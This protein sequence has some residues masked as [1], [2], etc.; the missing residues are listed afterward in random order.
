MTSHFC[1]TFLSYLPRQITYLHVFEPQIHFEGPDSTVH[2]A[3]DVIHN[4]AIGPTLEKWSEQAGK[5]LSL[6]LG[7]DG[8]DNLTMFKNTWKHSLD[9]GSKF[10][11]YDKLLAQVAEIGR[12]GR[13]PSGLL[14]PE[15][16]SLGVA[17]SSESTSRCRVEPSGRASACLSGPRLAGPAPVASAAFSCLNGVRVNSF[18]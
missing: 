12:S 13:S 2:L 15:L 8:E 17:D 14:S 3:K 11:L 16:E 6:F 4:D 5:Q 7:Q 1:L 18:L 10:C 9:Y